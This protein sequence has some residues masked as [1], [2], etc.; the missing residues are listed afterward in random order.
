MNLHLQSLFPILVLAVVALVIVFRVFKRGGLRAAMFHAPIK[1]T[2]GEVSGSGT[3]IMSTAVKVHALGGDSSEKAVGLEV[4][5]KS[6]AS[7][8]M[9]PVTL[10]ASE[11][12]KLARLL[13][14]ATV[15]EHAT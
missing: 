2:V 11:A 8:Q 1:R 3:K 6:V 13:Q 12:M 4:V 15:D 14:A 7:Y 9:L 10:S 5:A